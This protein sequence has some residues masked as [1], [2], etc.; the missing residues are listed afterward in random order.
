[1]FHFCKASYQACLLSDFHSPL[2]LQG[3]AFE[4]GN[5]PKIKTNIFLL[6]LELVEEMKN[7]KS[8]DEI[9]TLKVVLIQSQ[10]SELFRMNS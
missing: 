6:W 1:M 3:D 2:Q 7:C 10:R 9:E 8:L 4:P 5:F